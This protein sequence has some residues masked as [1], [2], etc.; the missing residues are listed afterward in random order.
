MNAQITAYISIMCAAGVLNLFLCIYAFYKR[1]TYSNIVYYFLAYVATI[2]IYCFSSAVGLLATS[3]E[4]IKFWTSVQYIGIAVSPALGLLFV[5]KYYGFYLSKI[6]AV[7]VLLIPTI[8][9]LMV[10]T[11]DWHHLHYRVFKVDPFL[12]V[13]FIYQEEGFW[14]LVHG[15]FCFS[16]MFAAFLFACSRWKETNKVYRPQ[17]ITI[18]LGQLIPIITAFLYLIDVTPRGVDPVPMVLWI[19]SALYLW[20]IKSSRL[21]TMMPI[22]KDT[23]FNSIN[24]GVVVLDD[25]KQLI[26]YNKAFQ[27][28]FP[29]LNK[30]MLGLNFLNMWELLTNKSFPYDFESLLNTK[31]LTIGEAED[32]KIYQI[33]ISPLRN[34]KNSKGYIIIFADITKLKEL[35]LQLERQAYYDELTQINNR[36]AFFQQCEQ[37][38]ITATTNS[39]PFT[40]IL[41]DIDHFKKVN[42]T[43]G[44][45][46]GDEIIVHVVNRC[47]TQLPDTALFARSGG[48]EFVIALNGYNQI[49]A[50]ALAKD[51]CTSMESQVCVTEKAS[52][53]VTVSLGIAEANYETAETLHQLLNKAD[54]AL[55]SAKKAG[56]NRTGVYEEKN[57]SLSI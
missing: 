52:L 13:P 33:S 39:T 47:K 15:T 7:L 49:D 36:R 57:I 3:I 5:L 32:R 30:T 38:F 18:I 29:Q 45:H 35:Q 50:L 12:G 28:I 40:I 51:L 43:Y 21:F 27:N 24:D 4:E 48:E 37:D 9:V 20:S 17:S 25:S 10:S 1:H 26:E 56:R 2:T 8:T 42:D 54:Q 55:Y 31:E 6:M 41:L 11:N 34:L 53:N 14:Y 23:I 46:I 22:D 16:Y 19:T 44:H